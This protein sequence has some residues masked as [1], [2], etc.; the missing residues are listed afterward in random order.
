M[1][2]TGFA[3]SAQRIDMR[4]MVDCPGVTRRPGARGK[5]GHDR[6]ESLTGE[7]VTAQGLRVAG[8]AEPHHSADQQARCGLPRQSPTDAGTRPHQA[9]DSMSPR[10]QGP[11]GG[12]TTGA[13]G[14][15]HEDPAGSLAREFGPRNVQGLVR[16][17]GNAA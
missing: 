17:H 14:A 15:E 9:D 4:L 3:R 8:V 10:E 1:R 13:S 16:G 12:S 2:N 11:Y 7:A 5:A 6:I